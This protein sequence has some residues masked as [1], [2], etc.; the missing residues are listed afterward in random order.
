MATPTITKTDHVPMITELLQLAEDLHFHHW[1]TR[2]Y[3]EHKALDFAYEE[4]ENFKDD[5]VERLVGYYGRFK[6]IRLMPIPATELLSL[7]DAIITSGNN[8]K[9]L[10]AKDNHT[11]L[12]NTGDEIIAVGSKLKYLLTLS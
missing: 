10:A 6:S 9:M 11:D 2:S 8:L 3:A 1:N 7:P 5:V 12:D 4:V